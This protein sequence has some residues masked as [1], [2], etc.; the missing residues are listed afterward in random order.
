MSVSACLGFV[1]FP[2]RFSLNRCAVSYADGSG[3][4][5][6]ARSLRHKLVCFQYAA[7]VQEMT[8]QAGADVKIYDMP[9]YFMLLLSLNC[10]QSTAYTHMKAPH[11]EL[12]L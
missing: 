4:P 2:L 10:V 12:V 11:I 8:R 3:I 1:V 6:D 9:M 5:R 7:V